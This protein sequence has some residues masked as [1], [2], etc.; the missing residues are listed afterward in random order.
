MAPSAP[1]AATPASASRK[2]AGPPRRSSIDHDKG[3]PS[4]GVMHDAVL[5][6]A[7]EERT[8][9]IHPQRH[10]APATPRDRLCEQRL[11]DLVRGIR[12][13]HPDPVSLRRRTGP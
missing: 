5:R 4:D 3:A 8:L 12:E 9:P 10:P 7:P 2:P 11:E 13:L 6:P 1:N